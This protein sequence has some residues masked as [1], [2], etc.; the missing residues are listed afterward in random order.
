[1]NRRSLL[2]SLA[3]VTAGLCTRPACAADPT[4]KRTSD[5]IYGRKHGVA[6]TLDVFQPAKPSGIGVVYMVSGGWY[7]SHDNINPGLL[8]GFLDRGQTVFAVVHGSQPKYAIPEIVQDI[9]RAVRWIHAHAA[10]YGVDPNRLGIAGGS[11]G[12]HLSLMQGSHGHAGDPAAKDPIDRE[13]SRVQAV[14]CFF[15]PTD[16]LNYGSAGV[17]AMHYEPLKPFRGAFAIPSQDPAVITSTLRSESPL[18][19]ATKDMPP[20]LIIH[21]N[22]D[23]LVPIQQ[24]EL[25]MSRLQ[26]L[27][28]DH[29][30]VVKE[31]KGH[32]WPGLEKDILILAEWFDQHLAK[33]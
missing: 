9:D 17:D 18:Y 29:R 24:S 26:E 4:W 30:L 16:F 22:A 27:G 11:A 19:A 8:Q 23:S 31:G 2:F 14:A 3:L 32:G 25:F 6:L 12:G 5:L 1:M 13:S 33:K 10:E 7:S 28:V 21:G 20:T 15:P